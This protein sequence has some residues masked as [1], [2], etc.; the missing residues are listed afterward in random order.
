MEQEMYKQ[1]Y[2]HNHSQ[3]SLLGNCY[4]GMAYKKGAFFHVVLH[5]GLKNVLQKQH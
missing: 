1:D 5:L 3:E 4:K 2:L